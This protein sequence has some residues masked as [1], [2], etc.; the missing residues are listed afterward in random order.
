MKES[1]LQEQPPRAEEPLPSC[2][3]SLRCPDVLDWPPWEDP[4]LA[5]TALQQNPIQ[6]YHPAFQSVPFHQ[7]PG[8]EHRGWMDG[9]MDGEAQPLPPFLCEARG[10]RIGAPAD[11]AILTRQQ[12]GLPMRIPADTAVAMLT[13]MAATVTLPHMPPGPPGPAFSGPSTTGFPAVAPC[14]SMLLTCPLTEDLE[15]GKT[16]FKWKRMSVTFPGDAVPS[17][18]R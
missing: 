2:P 10:P 16:A 5:P 11:G 4:G 6:V 17:L 18:S 13:R 12:A 7:A 8:L 1:S 9:W 3:A 14:C 15:D